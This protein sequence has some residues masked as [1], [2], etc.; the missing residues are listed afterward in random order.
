MI[1]AFIARTPDI[2]Q[3]IGLGTVVGV[4]GMGVWKIAGLVN[5]MKNRRR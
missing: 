4:M 5:R 2:L 1:W 3:F